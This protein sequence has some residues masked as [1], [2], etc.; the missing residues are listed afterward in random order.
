MNHDTLPSAITRREEAVAL[1]QAIATGADE[2]TL[3]PVVAAMMTAEDEQA[4]AI[5][6]GSGNE[7]SVRVTLGAMLTEAGLVTEAEV[8]EAL[9]ARRALGR[10]EA[11]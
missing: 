10:G 2:A 6:R 1:L 5:M 9:D 3:A 8:F 7:M 4:L 11:A